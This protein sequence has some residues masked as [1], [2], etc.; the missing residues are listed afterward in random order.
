[1]DTLKFINEQMTATE[2][3]YEFGEWTQAVTYPYTVGE[4]PSPEDMEAEDGGESVTLIVNGFHRGDFLALEEIKQKIKKHFHPVF[5]LRAQTE[6]GAIAVFYGGAFYVPTNEA[7]LKRI[8][9]N[10]I[11]KTWRG[12]I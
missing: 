2:V 7:D 12:D 6:N 8:Q 10:L 3:P 1:M 9:I 5:G 4:L 11:I